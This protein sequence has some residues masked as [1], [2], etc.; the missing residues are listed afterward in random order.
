MTV[1]KSHAQKFII[2]IL[3][4][5]GINY[6]LFKSTIK[7]CSKLELYTSSNPNTQKTLREINACSRLFV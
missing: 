2:P 5:T 4:E 6:Y 7:E 1:S 3:T